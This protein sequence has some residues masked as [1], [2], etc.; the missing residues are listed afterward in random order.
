M[1]ANVLKIGNTID[2]KFYTLSTY[3]PILF[4]DNKSIF[5]APNN[6]NY[7]ELLDRIKQAEI[8]IN[9]KSLSNFAYPFIFHEFWNITNITYTIEN[10]KDFYPLILP[11]SFRPIPQ[12]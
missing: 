8:P 7:I 12:H 6:A 4:G 2:S 3:E 10:P 11:D 9:S 1:A 5:L